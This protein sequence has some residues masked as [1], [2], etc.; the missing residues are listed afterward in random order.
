MQPPDVYQLLTNS[1]SECGASLTFSHV[2]VLRKTADVHGS[3][4]AALLVTE[5]VIG[6]IAVRAQNDKERMR[7]SDVDGLLRILEQIPI[8]RA[9]RV[10]TA[11]CEQTFSSSIL[12]S[13]PYIK[14]LRLLPF[15]LSDRDIHVLLEVIAVDEAVGRGY[16]GLGDCLRRQDTRGYTP[17]AAIIPIAQPRPRGGDCL[18]QFDEMLDVFVEEQ[19]MMRWHEHIAVACNAQLSRYCR[20]CVGDCLR[21]GCMNTMQL[22]DQVFREQIVHTSA[23]WEMLFA[24]LEHASVEEAGRLLRHQKLFADSLKVVGIEK[25]FE[26]IVGEIRMAAESGVGAQV[27]QLCSTLRVVEAS[28]MPPVRVTAVFQAV[29]RQLNP[30]QLLEAVAFFRQFVARNVSLRGMLPVETDAMVA[31]LDA[32]LKLLCRVSAKVYFSY[33]NDYPPA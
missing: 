13:V 17:F 15:V 6:Q 29:L 19:R 31:K 14:D 30:G 26:R 18:D 32:Q 28:A 24:V 4:K 5:I 20:R 2:Q 1:V 21:N 10:L 7:P 25:G 3:V 27:R 16:V 22:L 8:D 12:P 33:L 23:V 11:I 9:K